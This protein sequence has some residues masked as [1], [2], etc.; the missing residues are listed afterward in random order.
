M[1]MTST[2]GTAGDDGDDTWRFQLLRCISEGYAKK[3]ISFQSF[4]LET[5]LKLKK[6]GSHGKVTT[7][8]AMT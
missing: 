4:T 6:S 7:L 5:L 8:P 3:C 2:A 1:L